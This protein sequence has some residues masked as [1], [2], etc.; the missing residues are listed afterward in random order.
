MVDFHGLAAMLV[1]GRVCSF[2]TPIEFGFL[3][4]WPGMGP[5]HGRKLTRCESFPTSID[6]IEPFNLSRTF[7]GA[8][9]LQQLFCQLFLVG[10]WWFQIFLFSPL[11][12]ETIQFD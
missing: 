8:W 5:N 6:S 10:S 9:G 7:F 3:R 4:V 11:P 1:S 2:L 12:G